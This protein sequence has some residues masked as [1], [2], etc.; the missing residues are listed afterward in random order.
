MRVL[1]EKLQ[2][3]NSIYEMISTARMI[4]EIHFRVEESTAQIQC[5]YIH[6]Y[7]NGNKFMSKSNVTK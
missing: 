6:T 2:R 1:R 7:E 4:E 3:F 5:T